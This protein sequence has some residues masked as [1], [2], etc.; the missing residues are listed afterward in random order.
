MR[1]VATTTFDWGR[2]MWGR[3]DSP[4][5][6]L[7]SY[8]CGALPHVPLMLWDE[9]GACAQFCDDCVRRYWSVEGGSNAD[10]V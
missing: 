6:S 2:V 4:P 5:T 7:C 8:C 9:K 1:L 10:E 3:P